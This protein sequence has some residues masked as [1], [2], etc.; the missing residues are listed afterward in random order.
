MKNVLIYGDSNA[1]GYDSARY[2]PEANAFQRMTETERWPALVQ[3]MLGSDYH[4]IED[5][6]NGRT[7]VWDDP[8][9]PGRNG[10]VGLKMA[11]DANAPLDLVV[12]HLGCNELKEY[13]NL[14]AAMIA[15]GMEMLVRECN[16]PYYGYPAP[17]VLLIAPAPTHPDIATIRDGISFGPT[18]YPKSCELGKRYRVIAERNHCGFIDCAEFNFEINTMDGLHYS[19]ADHA[20][21]APVVAEKIREMLNG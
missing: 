20:R 5:A 16:V 1:W 17:K 18:A 19:R 13:F 4:I 12:I 10:L 9:M 15:R 11:L 2:V 21:L 3:T 7:V 8:Y 6:L 14:S